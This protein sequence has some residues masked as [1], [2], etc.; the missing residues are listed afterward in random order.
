MTSPEVAAEIQLAQANESLRQ[1]ALAFDERLRQEK[2][3][4]PIRL[5]MGWSAA[6][7]FPGIL[8]V[9]GWILFRH[10]AFDPATVQIATGTLLVDAVATGAGFYKLVL[11]GQPS[12]GLPMI[13]PMPAET[14]TEA[15]P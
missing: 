10:A 15:T 3:W 6:A 4:A 9:C 12:T 5:A 1:Q 11:A 8:F 14:E 2:R 13:T 7:V